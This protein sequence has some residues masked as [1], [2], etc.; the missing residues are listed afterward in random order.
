MTNNTIETKPFHIWEGIYDSFQSAA[1]E[2]I[3]PGFGG[4]IYRKRSLVAANECLAA[5]KAGRPIPQFHKQ[6]STLLPLTVAMMLS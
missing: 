2:A 1:A 6:R 4:E 3:G 5:L